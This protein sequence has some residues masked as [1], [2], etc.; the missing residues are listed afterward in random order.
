MTTPSE[1]VRHAPPPDRAVAPPG[2]VTVPRWLRGAG[3][4]SWRLL[5][6]GALVAAVLYLLSLLRVVVLP[7]IVATL[8][9]TLLHGPAE[10]LRRRGL[11]PAAAV[12]AVMAGAALLLVA[13][14]AAIAPSIG[15]QLNDLGTGVQD[16]VQKVGRV[17]AD[18]PFNLSRR[19]VSDRI[20]QGI[21]RL[22]QNS[23]PITHGVQTGAI[24]LGEVVT[25]LIITVLLTFFF[26]K[27]GAE[28]WRWFGS[29]MSASRRAHWDEVGA[30]IYV[31]LGG[32]V[33]GIALVGLVDALLIGL[34]LVVIGVPLVLPLMV[35]TFFG[36]FL[37]LIGA[38]LAGL[39]AVLIA[40]V[41]NG[42]LAALLVLGAIILVQQVE[43][44]LLYPLL[45]G[46]T[47]H[48]H[49]AAIIIALATGGVLAGIIGVFLAVPVAG[50]ISV[51]L[52]YARREP[53]PDSPVLDSP[54][55][56]EA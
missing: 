27:D 39:T 32:Y 26:L 9:S 22:R 11:P 14:I 16:G 52:G 49:P 34:A 48:L 37:P 41:S 28:M 5:A 10:A 45:M 1:P 15:S 17:L 38:F 35:L 4:A 18:P 19:E 40:L 47:V 53:P 6:V 2:D 29:F 51:L 3:A 46:R 36:A 50:V 33:R 23:G 30:R 20:D 42:V 8:A 7:V 21:Q 25:G 12:A 24:L 56:A 55:A 54:E 31:A 43:G 44:H 13:I